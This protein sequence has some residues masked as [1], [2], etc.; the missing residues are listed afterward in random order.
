VALN[1]ERAAEEARGVIH[2]LRPEYQAKGQQEIILETKPDQRA[3]AKPA[4]TKPKGKAVWPK[5]LA[6][7]VQA[8]ETALHAAA[9]PVSPAD[10]AKQ[11]ARAKPADVAEILATL[12]TLGRAR[13][14]SGGK[15]LR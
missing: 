4:P 6:E 11:F 13:R 10:L 5:A 1:A 15:F 12:A 2:W 14:A 7:R 9:A 3:K 8:V